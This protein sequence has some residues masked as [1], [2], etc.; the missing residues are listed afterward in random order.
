VSF[1]FAA[2]QLAHRGWVGA[3][4]PSLAIADSRRYQVPG[5]TRRAHIK[6]NKRVSLR[7]HKKQLRYCWNRKSTD[8]QG[9]ANRETSKTKKIKNQCRTAE[10]KAAQHSLCRSGEVASGDTANSIGGKAASSRPA[11]VGLKPR[12][13]KI[14]YLAAIAVAMIGWSWMLVMGLALALDI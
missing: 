13:L 1:E 8:R 7:H 9:G 10:K 6:L 5:L 4:E 2:S 14:L 11:S 3:P 12:F